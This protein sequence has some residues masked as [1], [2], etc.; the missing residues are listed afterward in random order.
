[1]RKVHLKI[2]FDLI[3]IFQLYQIT[4]FK[5]WKPEPTIKTGHNRK[6]IRVGTIIQNQMKRIKHR[7]ILL[8]AVVTLAAFMSSCMMTRTSVGTYRET[9]GNEY[10]YSKAKQWW[11]F[12]GIIPVGRTNTATPTNGACEVIVRHDFLDFVISGLTGGILTTMTIKV[13]A[14]K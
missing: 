5:K 11:L 6:A 12:W 8:T 2:K 1:M 9:K 14:K 4:S 7:L 13:K 10:T 3:I